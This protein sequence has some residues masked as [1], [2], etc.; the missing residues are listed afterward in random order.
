MFICNDA[1]LARY[2]VDRGVN[3]IFVDLESHGKWERQGHRDTLISGH[4]MEDVAAVRHAIP[5]SELLVRLNPLHQDSADE[6]D[7]SLAA[8]ADLLMLPMFETVEQVKQFVELVSG[9]ASVIPLV[10]TPAALQ[11]FGGIIAVPG[12]DE[13]YIGLNDLHMALGMHFMFEPLANGMVE[14]TATLAREQGIPFGFGGIARMS[15]GLLSGEM[16]LA[17]HLRLGSSAV[18]LSRTFHRNCGDVQQLQQTM[19][20]SAELQRLRAAEAALAQRSAAEVE[21]D[22][23]HLVE[24]IGEIRASI[25]HARA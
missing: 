9:R 11:D 2:A 19:D 20:F 17:E 15:E 3:R 25:A 12:V 7:Q 21:R 18:I 4:T 1:Q 6:V 16:V 14:Q 8:G 24:K 5:D 10:E 13:A 23:Q 22:H